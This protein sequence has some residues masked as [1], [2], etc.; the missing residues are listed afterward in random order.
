MSA[1]EYIRMGSSSSCFTAKSQFEFA[2][3][4]DIVEYCCRIGSDIIW[5]RTNL[6]KSL[7]NI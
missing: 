2:S 7:I 3:Q 6:L 4:S 1:I 5:R